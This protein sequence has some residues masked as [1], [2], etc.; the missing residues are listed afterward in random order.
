MQEF[1][2]QNI[3]FPSLDTCIEKEL[4]F[5]QSE[6]YVQCGNRP[7]I[8]PKNCSLDT[9][10]YFNAFF[11]KSWMKY[12][13]LD[14]LSCVLDLEGK[15]DIEIYEALLEDGPTVPKMI[16]RLSKNST[17]REYIKIEIPL[18]NQDMCFFRLIC[19]NEVAKFYGGSYV[20]KISSI[21]TINI[22][23]DL[24]TYRREEFIHKNLTKIQTDIFNNENSQLSK[25]LNLIVIDNGQSLKEMTKYSNLIFVQQRD[26]GSTGGYTRGMIE[27]IHHKDEWSL[28]HLILM[29]DDIILDTEVLERNY[30]LLCLLK[31][32]YINYFIGGTMLHYETPYIQQ[33]RGA[34]FDGKRLKGSYPWSDMRNVQ[35]L[36]ENESEIQKKVNFTGWWYSC[37]PMSYVREDNLPYPFFMKW[38]DVEYGYRNNPGFIHMNGIA[39]WHMSFERKYSSANVY[40]ETRNFLILVALY[41]SNRSYKELR[42]AIIVSVCKELYR[43]RY[44]D[45]RLVCQ[46][47]TD[48]LKGPEWLK[49]LE[50]DIF[51][52]E[53]WNSGYKLR[54]LEELGD[55]LKNFNLDAPHRNVCYENYI[56]HNKEWRLKKMISL[57][58]SVFKKATKYKTFMLDQNPIFEYVDAISVLNYD[59]TSNKGFIVKKDLQQWFFT[60][61]L[62]LKSLILFKFKHKKVAN[63]YIQEKK[64][65]QDITF[66]TTYLK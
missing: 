25:H 31:D 35:T 53:L 10:T 34:Y 48:F 45:A 3:M 39:I 64:I 61:L 43:Y 6:D 9:S 5:R 26:Y 18:S 4:Y 56:S 12:T 33:E 50:T 40:F 22:A 24:C 65:M 54:Y 41:Q 32:E 63:Q 30:A 44:K 55:E 28:T 60:M 47:V 57:F 11:I 38:D 14:N 66:W 17:V 37:I 20:T 19:Q 36:L 51:Y 8:F 1:V 49:S 15:F 42:Q 58:F 2:L 46:A 52:N 29:D 27:A 13:C 16:K 7:V 23:L 59:D 62:L 21:R